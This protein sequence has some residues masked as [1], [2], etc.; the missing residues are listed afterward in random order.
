MPA[1]TPP[2]ATDLSRTVAVLLAGGQGTRLHELTARECK[3]ALHFAGNHRIVDFTLANAVRSGLGRMIVATQ[4]R[5]ATLLRH[6]PAHWGQSFDAG[7]LALRDGR[8]VT[9]RAEGY[10]GTADAVLANADAIDAARAREVVVLAG[11]HVYDMDYAAM[12]AAHRASGAAATVAVHT[13][14][15]AEASSFGVVIADAGGRARGFVEKPAVAPGLPEDPDRA[16][17]SMGIYVFDWPWLRATL[18]ADAARTGSTHDFGH[19]I[20]PAAVAAGVVHAYRMPPHH[21]GRESYWRDVGTLDAYRAAQLEFAGP[22]TPCARPILPGQPAIDPEAAPADTLQF[23]FQLVSGG[24]Q[25][26]APRFR[27]EAFDRWTVLDR[28]VVLPGA[29]VSPG[30]RLTDCIVAPATCVPAGL[31]VGE[32]PDEDAR[33]FRRTDGGTTLVTSTMLARRHAER[34]RSV[35]AVLPFGKARFSARMQ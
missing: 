22:F 18:A 1:P 27:P 11:D 9:G 21:L 25:L 28:S 2:S 15:V 26:C 20:L 17:V 16:L 4:Y 13:V 6:L 34:P 31:V 14:P 32:D 5:P 19:D 33:W 3:P 12:V 30:A 10:L 35:P 24:L 8:T 7:G 23:G 29:R